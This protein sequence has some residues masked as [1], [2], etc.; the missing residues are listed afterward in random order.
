M[1]TCLCVVIAL[2]TAPP[3]AEKGDALP[4]LTL[5]PQG[6]VLLAGK[7]YRGVG[8]NYFSCFLRTL[9]QQ[10]STSYEAGFE[11]L[12]ERG[13]PFARFCACGFW[14]S[15]MKLYQD[16]REEYFRRMDG[17]VCCA[18]K[19]GVG[20]IPSLFWQYACV[21]DLVGEPCDQWGNAA[22]RTHA[23]MRQYVAEVVTRYKDSPA[24]WAWEFGNEYNLAADLP[25]AAQH[26]PPVWPKLGTAAERSERDQ[27][28][29]DMLVVAWREFGREVRKHDPHRLIG[30]GNSIL[31]ESA[32]HNR[33][34]HSWK[35]DTPEQ[36][37]QMLALTAP[38]PINLVSVHCYEKALARVGDVAAAAKP[39]GK[40]VFVGEFQVDDSTSSAA[41]PA[42][43]EFLATLDRH[44]IPLAAV[45]VFDLP[46]QTKDFSITA[47]NA[48][49]WQLE[50][51]RDWNRRLSK[52]E[53]T[54]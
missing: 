28:T 14:P 4:G 23:F 16:D 51:L 36:F 38:E 46:A 40:P 44:A 17:V 24:I 11:L 3:A 53:G 52:G 1:S 32:W 37:T 42:M 41:R 54:R 25:N 47:D 50:V 15:D 31:R 20:L 34:E 39:L 9:K 33:E 12:G 5:G 35:P 8:V 48:R 2:C 45:W 30:T 43:N 29:S 6:T 13:I 18:E 27:L 10:P 7:P 49:A 21:P 22:S 26:R 19:H